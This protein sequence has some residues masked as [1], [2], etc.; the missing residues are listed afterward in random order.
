[1]RRQFDIL[2]VNP[3]S[4]STKVAWF[5][6]RRMVS[7]RTISH[8]ASELAVYRH[9]CEQEPLRVKAVEEFIREDVEQDVRFSAV[10]G[11]GGLLRPVEGGV[12]T[13]SAAMLEDLRLARYGEHASNLGAVLAHRESCRYRC[14]AYT[15][16]PVVVD[17]LEEAARITGLPEIRRKSIFHALNQRAAARRVAAD[18][19]RPY[20][21]LDLIVA[22]MGGGITVGAHR[23]GRVVDVNNGL[24]GDGPFSAERAGGLPAGQLIALATNGRYS[25]TDLRR[26]LAGSGGLVAYFGTNDLGALRDRERKGDS[27]VTAVLDALV[28]RVAQ[29]IARHG[30]TLEGKVDAIVLTGGMTADPATVAGIERKTG[31]LAPVYLVPGEL[32]MEALAEAA[33]S[34]LSGQQTPKVYA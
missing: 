7:K 24:D 29:E 8:E 19:G 9:V 5:R 12:Y 10:V 11:R 4:T 31:F 20:E 34:V 13:I 32:E 21:E 26:K 15:V 23:H 18:L 1:M 22:H 25:E 28:L 14:P 2:V 30:A 16:D 33:L 17:E 3:G 6:N 27:T